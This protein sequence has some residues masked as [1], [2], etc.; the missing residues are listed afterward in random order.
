[1]GSWEGVNSLS[2]CVNQRLQHPGAC[3][4]RFSGYHLFLFLVNRHFLVVCEIIFVLV[5]LACPVI[6]HGH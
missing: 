6:L 3:I 2:L 5:P 1:M 4:S